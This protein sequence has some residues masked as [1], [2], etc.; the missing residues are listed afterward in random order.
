[1]HIKETNAHIGQNKVR[2]YLVCFESYDA[3]HN[4][5]VLHPLGR[6]SPRQQWWSAAA[7]EKSPHFATYSSHPAEKNFRLD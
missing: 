7:F 1:M 6:L 3:L 5:L 4:M 2:R